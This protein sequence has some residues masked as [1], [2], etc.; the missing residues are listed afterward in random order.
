MNHHF[1]VPVIGRCIHLD[2][3]L[4]TNRHMERIACQ[5][6]K[7]VRIPIEAHMNGV[8][9]GARHVVRCSVVGVVVKVTIGC[10]ITADVT[11]YFDCPVIATY[12]E[13]VVSIMDRIH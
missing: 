8:V 6:C 1:D 5:W 3:D 2:V 12:Y 11:F 4:R 9:T 10:L 13:W 7:E